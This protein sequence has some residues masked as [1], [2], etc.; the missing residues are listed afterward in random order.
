MEGLYIHIPFCKSI[1]AYC[2][3]P[4]VVTKKENMYKYVSA[5]KKEI[6]YYQ[7][8]IK[9]IKTLYI[10]GGTPSIL[11]L[12]LFDDLLSHLAKYVDLSKL[13]EFSVETNPQDL[14]CELIN[15]FKKFYVSRISI[16]V[17]TFDK[18]LGDY[19]NRINS[20]ELVDEKIKMIREIGDFDINLDM[21]YKLPFQTINSLKKDLEL[22]KKL[23][24]EH[25]S[26][27]SLILEEKTILDYRYKRNEFDILN[28]EI[29]LS[30]QELIDNELK[31]L[32]FIKYEISN[33]A[34]ESHKGKHNLLYWNLKEY[35][36][37]GAAAHSQFNNKRL[38]N[39]S[40]YLK[41]IEKIENNELDNLKEEYEFDSFS[42]HFLMGLRKCEGVKLE[43]VPTSFD[44]LINKYPIL[45]YYL[46]NGLLV[47]ENGYLKFTS[48]GMNL[49][50]LVVEVFV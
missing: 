28:E 21:M 36:G 11:P 38:F 35:L 47:Y 7:N 6:D 13:I 24:V 17:E 8:D 33:Y 2:D 1:C 49:G 19:L 9:N 32:G 40:D 4:K 5:L 30:M 46:E 18:E 39:P 14:S 31:D 42:E 45:D 16:G 27:Y 44:E 3:F 41:Y 20:F 26:Y 48:R 10:G 43:D 29:E 12:D 34:K 37:I 50:N 23:D 25:I 22:I 15:L